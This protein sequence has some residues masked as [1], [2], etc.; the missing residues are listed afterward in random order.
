MT[1]QGMPPRGYGGYAQHM[2]PP[3]MMHGGG[4]RGRMGGHMGMHGQNSHQVRD[5]CAAVIAHVELEVQ[6]FPAFSRHVTSY[7]SVRE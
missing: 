7:C 1:P 2:P 3:H 5:V 4:G 6:G